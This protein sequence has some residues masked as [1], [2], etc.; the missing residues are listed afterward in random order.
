MFRILLS[1]FMVLAV[2][3][4]CGGEQA[5]V[6]QEWWMPLLSNLIE[7]VLA[8]FIPVILTLV[9]TLLRRWNLKVEQEQLDKIATQVSDWAEHHADKA[10]RKGKPKTSGA[11][12]MDMALIAA[13][14]LMKQFKVKE[15]VK[16]SLQTIIES[17]LGEKKRNEK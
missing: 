15:R 12:K 2:L 4:G 6:S 9:S 1:S 11:E 17:K 14:E 5:G 10:L 3:T 7:I 8:I 13:D 16:G